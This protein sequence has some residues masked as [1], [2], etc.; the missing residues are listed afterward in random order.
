MIV[1]DA[2]AVVAALAGS[3][4]P[5]LALRLAAADSWHAPHLLDTEVLHA[6]RRLVLAGHLTARRASLVRER[7]GELTIDRHPHAPLSDRVWA[8]RGNLSAYDATYVALA[9]ALDLPLVTCDDRLAHAPGH[10]AR[11]ESFGD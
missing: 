7:F 3:P 5:D 6:L 11:I 2:S 10:R 8:L 1:A 4:N 9:E